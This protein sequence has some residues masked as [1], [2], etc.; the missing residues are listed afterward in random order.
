MRI[1]ALEPSDWDAVRTIYELGI[2]TGAATFE[3]R[4]PAWEQWDQG[5]SPGRLV[6]T[7]SA[8]VI[9]WVAL[10]PVSDRCV[11]EGIAEC[12][13][14]VHPNHWEKVLLSS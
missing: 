3:N 5:H 13:I 11:Y 4:A 7:E 8:H 6:A 14:Y 2:A 1:R 9:A 10:S 12:S